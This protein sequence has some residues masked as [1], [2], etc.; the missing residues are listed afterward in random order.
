MDDT[1]T[2]RGIFKHAMK[3][4]FKQELRVLC[5]RRISINMN[6]VALRRDGE[7]KLA[8]VTSRHVEYRY[9]KGFRAGPNPE[10]SV[11]G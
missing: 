10:L 5:Y 11:V 1:G 8:A 6:K 3:H 2:F 9:G 7:Q 4:L